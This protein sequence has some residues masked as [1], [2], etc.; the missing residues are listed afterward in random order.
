MWLGMQPNP[1]ALK[2]QY[3]LKTAAP[4]VVEF[5]YTAFS[6]LTV[7]QRVVIAE[8]GF[9]MIIQE[10]HP[11]LTFESTFVSPHPPRKEEDDDD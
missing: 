9:D 7:E 5:A 2:K 4:P 1:E 8:R 10:K 11:Y 6:T 3:K